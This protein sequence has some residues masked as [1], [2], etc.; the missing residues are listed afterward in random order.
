MR[1]QKLSV[2]IA[3]SM[4]I[5]SALSGFVFGEM[6]RK[7]ETERM[8]SRLADQADYTVSLINGL[9]LEA[10]I[11]Q[12][13]PVLESAMQ[14]A[15]E[16]NQD[17]LSV[18]IYDFFDDVIA[19]HPRQEL[20]PSENSEVHIQDIVIEDETF[21]KMKVV[22]STE[23]GQLLIEQSVRE[24]QIAIAVI[25]GAIFI[26]FLSLM[27]ILAMRPINY[28]YHRMQAAT[29]FDKMPSHGLPSF[30]SKEF[31]EL[32]KSVTLLS[33]TLQESVERENAL[34][35]A[36]TNADLANRAKSEFLANMSHEIRTPMNGVIGMTEL[37]METELTRD[38]QIY[39][40]TISQSG[41]A[42]LAIINDILDFSKIKAGKLELDP[43]PFNLKNTLEDTSV[44][45]AS[46]IKDK[47]VEL[48]LRYHPDL[49]LSF[50]G[51]IGRI[52]QIIT[53]VAGNAVKFTQK[54]SVSIDV[55][56]EPKGD[57]TL[58]VIEIKDTG[59]GIPEEKLASIFNAFEQVDGAAN[60]QFEGTGLGLAISGRLL[61][62][63]DGHITAHSTIGKGSVFTISFALPPV[64]DF[65]CDRPKDNISLAD[66]TILIV[67]DL[68]INRTLL[69][70]Q[71]STLGAT[72]LAVASGA[73][74]LEVLSTKS[75]AD[76][77]DLAILDYQMPNM[78]GEA[79][80]RRL[81]ALLPELPIIILSSV[82]LG[83][84]MSVR[85]ELNLSDILLKPARS[86]VLQDSIETAFSNPIKKP[87]I[88]ANITPRDHADA[89]AIHILAAEDNKTNQL[90]LKSVL[91]SLNANIRIGDNGAKA[92]DLYKIAP[93]DIVLMDMSMPEMDGLEATAKIRTYEADSG[94]PRIPI[95]ALTANAMKGDRDRCIEAGMDDYLSKPINKKAVLATIDKWIKQHNSQTDS[96]ENRLTLHA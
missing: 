31:V 24:A 51:D 21:G 38:Q 2:L 96:P 74:A 73:E 33:T 48:C 14:Q 45:L 94:L 76:K 66:K 69:C 18:E 22:W 11:V 70:E 77:I 81:R 53:N 87:S 20:A 50:N 49:P 54:G 30:A 47:D 3:I 85:S 28:V 56:G 23:R 79:L 42:L 35:I 41:T 84:K 8:Q 78:D 17:L 6:V 65:E 16:R 4:A 92:V 52:R 57:E 68:Q 95:V 89:K 75:N 60:R 61:K 44:M 39:A 80:S 46:D 62:L 9:M 34:M 29:T 43:R 26:A 59:I 55:T 27:H 93:P 32:N 40:E 36:K 15:Q 90:V 13:I 12:D 91:K 1:P 86:K 5:T 82:D 63:M 25:L 72:P 83:F 64:P 7:Y 67:D 71:L 58:L 19:R 37:I 88:H 10:I